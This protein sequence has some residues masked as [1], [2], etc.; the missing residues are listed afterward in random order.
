MSPEEESPTPAEHPTSAPESAQG[1]DRE[2]APADAPGHSGVRWELASDTAEPY[3]GAGDPTV[4]CGT[5]RGAAGA[6][7][8]TTWW[9]HEPPAPAARPRWQGLR[10]AAGV[11]VSGPSCT[12]GG[13]DHRRFHDGGGFG[14]QGQPGQAQTGQN[15]STSPSVI[16]GGLFT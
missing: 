8:V 2:E 1:Q 13:V 9:H 16:L 10:V 7:A 5:R 12:A 11:G 3:E 4:E 14:A 15:T 6:P